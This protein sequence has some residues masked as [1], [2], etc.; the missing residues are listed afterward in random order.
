MSLRSA[1]LALAAVILVALGAVPA[2]GA[3]RAPRIVG[4]HVAPPGA[5]PSVVSLVAAGAEPEVGHGCGGTLVDPATVLTAAHCVGGLTPDDFDVVAGREDLADDSTG[6]RIPAERYALHPDGKDV[7]LV[8]LARPAAAPPGDLATPADAALYAPGLTSIAVG[9]GTK[10]ENGGA[11]SEV[12][13]EVE[14]PIVSDA[15]CRA[16]YRESGRFDAAH[17]ICAGAKGRDSCTGD[18]GGPLYVRAGD[19][20]LLQVGVTSFGRGCARKRFPGV[21]VEVPAVL[22]FAADP[23][24]VF[25]P[26]PESRR[27]EIRG[28]PRVGKRLRCDEGEWTGE[29]IRFRYLWQGGFATRGRKRSFVPGRGLAGERLACLVLGITDGG[30]VELASRPVRV[31]G[32]RRG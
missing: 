32:K 29:A 3:E 7:A 2:G 10:R 6:E 4:G 27:A 16:A 14:V 26:V 13:R 21:Y 24:P 31:R 19:G 20:A 5:Y 28:R 22:D 25:A 18:S 17:L 8:R 9:W 1:A 30:A 15:D 11:I 12:L 23:E